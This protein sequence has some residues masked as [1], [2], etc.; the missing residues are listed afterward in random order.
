MRFSVS[1]LDL[2]QRKNLVNVYFNSNDPLDPVS[3]QSPAF[4]RLINT[5][6]TVIL[7]TSVIYN[8]DNASATLDF[9][10]DLSDGN[11]QP[12]HRGIDGI[13]R[14]D[15]HRHQ[16]RVPVFRR[17]VHDGR[18]H[19][20]QSQ[21]TALDPS[22][23]DLYRVEV[24]SNSQQTITANVSAGTTALRVRIFRYNGT[25]ATEIASQRVDANTVVDVTGL[26]TPGI[27]DY[28]IGISSDGNNAYNPVDGSGTVNGA[29]TGSY[30]L[31]LNVTDAPRPERQQFQLQIPRPKS[32]IWEPPEQVVTA[33]IQP[34]LVA[35]ASG[36]GRQR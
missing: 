15:C 1:D 16:S 11:L 3:A 30:R 31:N 10:A 35:F 32:E 21:P 8:A 7:P 12:A 18:L 6:G 22:D 2:V 33:P 28:F 27:N 4:Y 24:D 25:T 23:M 34:Q 9:G 5:D 17:N 29:G 13:Q 26:T 36:T 14:D 20:R 19:R